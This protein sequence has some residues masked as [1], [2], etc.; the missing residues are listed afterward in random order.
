MIELPGFT[1]PLLR[2]D[3]RGLSRTI[4]M[5]SALACF[6]GPVAANDFPTI[7]RVLFVENC[8]RE[9]TD[10]PRQEMLYKCSCALD[11]I[12]EEANYDEFV[13]MSTANDAG[14]IAGERGT[15]VRESAEG[16]SLTKRYKELRAKAAQTCFIQ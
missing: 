7:E 9:H 4:V 11:A 15:Q 6:T 8:V 16:R 1:R 2:I 14:Q 3:C 13:E 10:R 5:G 12:A